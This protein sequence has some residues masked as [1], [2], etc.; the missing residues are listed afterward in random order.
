MSKQTMR[1]LNTNTNKE[2]QTMITP[3][4][5]SYGYMPANTEYTAFWRNHDK[6]F[7]RKLAIRDH[8]AVQLKQIQA[9]NKQKE[10][11]TQ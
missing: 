8:L 10:T 1:S 7:A 5:P 4:T 11:P 2:T 3:I 9:N 6:Q